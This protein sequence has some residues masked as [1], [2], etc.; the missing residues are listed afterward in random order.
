MI[1]PK[2]TKTLIQITKR[3]RWYGIF[4][5]CIKT[6][7]CKEA[8]RELIAD[9]NSNIELFGFEYARQKLAKFI[10]FHT[11]GNLEILIN[12]QPSPSQ[13]PGLPPGPGTTAAGRV[14]G[15]ARPGLPA[16][17]KG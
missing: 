7:Y 16:K 2:P 17:I 1:P 12:R 13:S 5:W 9:C 8:W 4:L 15:A 10:D 3:N 11:Q 14:V 6:F